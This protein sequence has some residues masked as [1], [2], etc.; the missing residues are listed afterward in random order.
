MPFLERAILKTGYLRIKLMG[1]KRKPDL[2]DELL[3]KIEKLSPEQRRVLMQ[4]ANRLIQQ[5]N[6]PTVRVEPFPLE[7]PFEVKVPVVAKMWKLRQQIAASGEP[8]LS[9]E[10]IDELIAEQRGRLDHYYP[11]RNNSHGS[12]TQ[13]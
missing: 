9:R 2:I 6:G 5:E 10:E 11:I 13:A 4:K 3:E 7:P 1:A 8:P 12:K